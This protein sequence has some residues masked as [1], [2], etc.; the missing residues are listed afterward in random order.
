MESID[1]VI[2]CCHNSLAE[3]VKDIS[4]NVQ[5]IDISNLDNRNQIKRTLARQVCFY[6]Y[7][8]LDVP[9]R[10]IAPFDSNAL[11]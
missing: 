10:L 8:V 1:L 4:L 6:E 3:M 2:D 5:S 7:Q 11:S 9:E